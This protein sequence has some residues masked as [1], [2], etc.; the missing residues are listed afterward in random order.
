MYAIVISVEES[1]QNYYFKIITWEFKTISF[2][3]V[4]RTEYMYIEIL[5]QHLFPHR[6]PYFIYQW[7]GK[8]W[9]SWTLR[10]L[11]EA[12]HKICLHKTNSVEFRILINSAESVQ[13]VQPWNLQNDKTHK[14]TV[15]YS[16]S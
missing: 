16:P 6:L 13:T 15:N 3:R 7:H 11:E 1:Y 2:L 14:Q 9:K 4:I 5:I 8:Q 10:I 12:S